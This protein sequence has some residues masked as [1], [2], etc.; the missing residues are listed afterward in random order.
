MYFAFEIISRIGL[1][2]VL[3]VSLLSWLLGPLGMW[4]F[5][6]ILLVLYGVDRLIE[7]D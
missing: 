5:G 7:R 4:D 1:L 3:A 6:M 2:L